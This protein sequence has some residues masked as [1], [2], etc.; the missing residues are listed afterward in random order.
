MTRPGAFALT[1]FAKLLAEELSGKQLAESVPE[2][3]S[4][5][6]ITPADIS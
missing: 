4:R 6:R 3:P 2:F 5:E 1:K